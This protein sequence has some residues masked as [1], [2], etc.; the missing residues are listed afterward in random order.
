MVSGRRNHSS[1]VPAKAGTQIWTP[2]FAGVT[3]ML[4]LAAFITLTLA[5][6]GR[7][8]V[9]DYPPDADPRPGVLQPRRD[10]IRYY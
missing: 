2:A 4:L 1:V 6:C 9:P 10:P 7:K 8:D 5:A 3:K